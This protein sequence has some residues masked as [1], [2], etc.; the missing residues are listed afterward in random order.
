MLTRIIDDETILRERT[1][2]TDYASNK[3]VMRSVIH[4]LNTKTKQDNLTHL[5][6]PQI[7]YKHRIICIRL[8]NATKILINPII[9][10]GKGMKISFEKCVNLPNK[11][12]MIPRV[13]DVTVSYIDENGETKT[14]RF[15]GLA[16]ILIQHSMDHL[17]GILLD[18]LGLEIDEEFDKASDN[19][20]AEVIKAYIEMLTKKQKL[21]EQEI[22]KDENLKRFN[23]SI[24]ERRKN[25]NANNSDKKEERDL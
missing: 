6:A 25:Q 4:L 22:E 3:D 19:E 14:E 7:G 1:E 18:D 21:I 16:A 5:T 15:V 20:R 10:V 11:K 13:T 24:D 12:F 23:D 9:Y 17:E 8:K 2:E